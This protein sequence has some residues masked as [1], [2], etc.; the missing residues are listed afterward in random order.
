MT[1]F[2]HIGG[3]IYAGGQPITLADAE[4]AHS[5]LLDEF[6]A[7]RVHRR[8]RMAEISAREQPLRAAIVAASQWRRA[9]GWSDPREADATR[10]PVTGG[11]GAP[12]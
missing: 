3:T 2:A 4:F 9:G 1:P 10:T 12:Q 11:G 6:L 7:A 5:C 8:D